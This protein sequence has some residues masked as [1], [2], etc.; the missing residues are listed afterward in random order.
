VK[1]FSVAILLVAA[2]SPTRHVGD[3]C[4]NNK[5]CASG[6]C[7]D[8]LFPGGYCTADCSSKPCADGQVC[9]N[10]S[11]LSLC[12]RGC[13][14][15]ADCHRDGYQC[16]NFGCIPNCATDDDCG[17]GF[18]CASGTC[19]KKPGA[20]AGAACGV[21][22]D[23][24]SGL[25]LFQK[26][27]VSCTRDADCATTQTCF[28]DPLGNGV[29][30]PTTHITPICVDRRGK[31]APGATCSAD[32]DCDRGACR[33]G[34]CVE[35][36]SAVS[37]CHATSMSCATMVEPTDDRANPTYKGCLPSKGVIDFDGSTGLL[38]L[39]STAQ[40]FSIYVHADP[41]DFNN[42]AGVTS[43]TDPSNT[44]IFTP[45]MTTADFFKLAVRYEIT[46]GS[47]TMLVP[48]S[49]AVT[50]M[51]ALYRFTVGTGNG[52]VP[53]TRVYLKL[54]DAPLSSGSLPLNIYVTNLSGACTS[55][56]FAQVKNGAFASAI[57]E[58]QRIFQQAN[59]SVGPVTFVDLSSST[60]PNTIRVPTS[61]TAT[62][63][64]DLDNLLAAATAG[65][66]TTVGFDVVILR[67]IT[68]ENM[69]QSGVLGIAGGV[70][71]NPVLGTEHSGVAVSIETLCFNT[72]AI[73]GATMSHE[74]AHSVGLFHSI[75]MTGQHDPLTDTAGDGRNNLMYWLEDSGEHLSLQQGQVIRNDVK[76]K[77]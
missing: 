62:P 12:L 47:S 7:I 68:D 34:L 15:A 27:E 52:G 37:D 42:A 8:N 74:L 6:A 43:L 45:P 73:F 32:A 14:T 16:F 2:C 23:C 30:F 50:L 55:V 19:M 29:K 33:L 57:S 65:R 20:A 39:P 41:F 44:D 17:Q 71:A 5:D 10:V 48:N 60:V 64:P 35:M 70:P 13:I 26:C 24:S 66:G 69:H 76:V 61:T 40:T 21:N 58:L 54:A 3:T 72:Q 38:P 11:G 77:Q 36:C 51:P 63:L 9:G 1:R 59:V 67:S 56:T 46:E 22:E 53:T 75:E 49:P 25:C 28:L 18:M 4:H 31:A